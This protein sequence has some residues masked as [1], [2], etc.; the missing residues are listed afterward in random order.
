[1]NKHWLIVI[2]ER[3]FIG[4]RFKDSNYASDSFNFPSYVEEPQN[5]VCVCKK[6]RIPILRTLDVRMPKIAYAR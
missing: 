3:L 2:F 5:T 1:M 4:S 6:S